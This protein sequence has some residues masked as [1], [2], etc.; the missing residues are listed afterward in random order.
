MPGC[1]TRAL[2][3]DTGINHTLE[4]AAKQE[5]QMMKKKRDDRRQDLAASAFELMDELG[6]EQR[7]SLQSF[8]LRPQ[9]AAVTVMSS[10]VK[11]RTACRLINCLSSQ[12]V[13][14]V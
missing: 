6:A 5:E 9:V 14:A 3:T 10:A 4:A 1:E 13:D 8:L 7:N 12:A 2:M 11:K